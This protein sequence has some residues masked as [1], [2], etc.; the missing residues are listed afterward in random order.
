M[1]ILSFGIYVA[2][3]LFALEDSLVLSKSLVIIRFV[4]QG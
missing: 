4:Y 2:D 3:F 1:K